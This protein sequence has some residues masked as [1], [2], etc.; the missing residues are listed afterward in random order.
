MKK[1]IIFAL[2]LS[3]LAFSLVACGRNRNN[4]NNDGKDTGKVT[5][6]ENGTTLDPENGKVSDTDTGTDSSILD[7]I[8]SGL[9][10]VET[11]IENGMRRM[12]GR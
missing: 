11:G 7:P 9:D 5:D 10:S 2:V 4:N 8:E 6:T 3:L 1:F 12:T